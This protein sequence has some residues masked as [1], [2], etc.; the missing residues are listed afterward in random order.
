MSNLNKIIIVSAF[1]LITVA[2]PANAIFGSECRS[3]K[4]SYA[5]YLAQAKVLMAA[6]DKDSVIRWQAATQALK[7][8][9]SNPKKY[10]DKRFS[11]SPCLAYELNATKNPI[12]SYYKAN[13]EVKNANQVIL[14]N[15][16]CFKP[17]QVVEA[18]RALG[19]IK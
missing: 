14:N 7:L 2:Q 10:G 18:Q 13:I 15:Q 1:I 6:E 8:C 4:K 11:T 9:K 12:P 3:P 17:E 16:K 5:N 19:L